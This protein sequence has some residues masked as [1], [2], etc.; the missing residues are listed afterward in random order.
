MLDPLQSHSYILVQ[1]GAAHPV[2]RST[3]EITMAVTSG[4]CKV[5]GADPLC[6]HRL[7]HTTQIH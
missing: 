3:A 2:K 6:T 7:L 4:P 5:V 1:R